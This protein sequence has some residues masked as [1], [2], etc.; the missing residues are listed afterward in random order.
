MKNL[1]ATSALFMLLIAPCALSAGNLSDV[2]SSLI[3]MPGK[4]TRSICNGVVNTVESVAQVENTVVNTAMSPFVSLTKG[5][6]AFLNTHE[7]T[8]FRLLSVAT[9]AGAGYYA[10]KMYK[11]NCPLS[12]KISCK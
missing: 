4:L 6:V 3:S 8:I 10:Q 2:A 7:Q 1:T 11:K 5:T 12:C 9:L